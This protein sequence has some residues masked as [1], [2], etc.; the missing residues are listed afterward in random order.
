MTSRM[1]DVDQ[2]PPALE[3]RPVTACQLRRLFPSSR[4]V[5][6]VGLVHRFAA[7]GE[8]MLVHRDA[9]PRYEPVRLYS[10][11]RSAPTRPGISGDASVGYA[12]K[13]TQRA[14]AGPTAEQR[15]GQFRRPAVGVRFDLRTPFALEAASALA[16]AVPFE[17]DTIAPAWPIVFP[18]GAVKPAM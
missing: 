4:A 3:A 6:L 16:A 9:Q 17:P 18:G 8:H 15:D 5:S 10:D 7:L 14:A 12:P 13:I 11:R 1:L 2:R